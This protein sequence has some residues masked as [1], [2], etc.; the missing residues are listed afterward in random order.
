MHVIPARTS[1]VVMR[2]PNSLKLDEEFED[3][4]GGASCV[5]HLVNLRAFCQKKAPNLSVV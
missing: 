2:V 5:I 1:K 4:N 3:I